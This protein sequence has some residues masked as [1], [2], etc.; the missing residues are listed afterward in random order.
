MKNQKPVGRKKINPIFFTPDSLELSNWI[1]E[2]SE[3]ESRS[4]ANFVS[5]ILTIAMRQQKGETE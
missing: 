3:I 1:D 4:K 2:E 5:R